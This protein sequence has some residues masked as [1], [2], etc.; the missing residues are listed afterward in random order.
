MKLWKVLKGESHGK[1]SPQPRPSPVNFGRKPPT[2]DDVTTLMAYLVPKLTHQVENAATDALGY[3]LNKSVTSREALTDFLG[4]KGFD[5]PAIVRVE[6][7]VVIEGGRADMAGYDETDAT[8]LLVES[9]FWAPLRSGQASNY[10]RQTTALLF[11][12]P[13]ARVEKLWSE[14]VQQ[15]DKESPDT[16]LGPTTSANGWRSTMVAGAPRRRW[17]LVDVILPVA[18]R[19]KR[20]AMV[21]G[22]PRRL[23][24]VSWNRLLRNMAD[25]TGGDDGDDGVAE[26]I[27]QLR[28]L[29]KRQERQGVLPMYVEE[30]EPR[31]L[32]AP[33]RW[34]RHIQDLLKRVWVD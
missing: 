27:R 9:K 13:G 30:I 25:R 19:A 24:L 6:T 17:R 8:R 14:I 22:A 31:H 21:A 32:R 3:I 29:V 4:E 11:I 16:K 26:D 2:S 7:E 23:A 18:W 12:A 10:L 33:L 15:I 28:G 5:I 20:N 34:L 1:P